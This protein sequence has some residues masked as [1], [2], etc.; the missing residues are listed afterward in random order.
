MAEDIYGFLLK[1]KSQNPSKK[2]HVPL[3]IEVDWSNFIRDSVSHQII[4]ILIKW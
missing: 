1:N 4:S 3:S 2:K